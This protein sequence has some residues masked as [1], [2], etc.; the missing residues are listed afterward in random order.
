MAVNGAELL[1]YACLIFEE[2]Q[3]DKALE[4]FVLAYMNGF[5]QQLVLDTIYDCYMEGNMEE[6]RNAFQSCSQKTGITFEKC[7]LD[8]I[9]YRE[10]EYFIFDREEGVFRGTFSLKELEG[11]VSDSNFQDAEFSAGAWE[12]DWDWRQFQSDL[13][14]AKNRK[15]Y[16]IC[17][18]LER[19][20]SFCKVPE[21]AKYMK[22]VTIFPSRID[23]QDYFHKNI[24]IYLPRILSGDMDSARALAD[25][26]EEEHRYRLTTKG[27]N[28]ANVLLT[29]GIPTHNRG[30]LLLKRLENLCK[31]PYD[32]EVEIVISK[33]GSGQYEKE[34]NIVKDMS[35]ARIYYKDWDQELKAVENWHHVVEMAHGK[36]VLFVSDED[37]ICLDA[38]EHYLSCL[39]SYPSVS[40]V[41]AK[42]N[43][44]YSS[45][46]A[47]YAPQGIKAFR[48]S[49][50]VQ[51][52]LSGL[53]VRREDFLKENFNQLY[54]EFNTN[55]FLR[56]YPHE[57][58][59]AVLSQRGDYMSD[60]MTLIWEGES[61]N[62]LGINLNKEELVLPE[63]ATYEARLNQF[64]GMIDFL[65]WLMGD[66]SL[67]IAIGLYEAID[68]TTYLFMMARE[69]G[70]A[71]EHLK[72]WLARFYKAGI[73]AINEFS[74]KQEYA[75]QLLGTLKESCE[76]ILEQHNAMNKK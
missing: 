20:V 56:Y 14:E 52:Y 23:F 12:M 25:M 26:I 3:Y 30:K 75:T 16:V 27:R 58:W 44:T 35:D 63:Y 29:I 70:H 41:R 39:K 59:C 10:R 36:Y 33:N 18:D 51:N 72:E 74:L 1:D 22:H 7:T 48:A 65:H 38:L 54:R 69:Y 47:H 40:V 49:F 11:T 55:E 28:I 45:L 43:M 60:E 4:A 53:I 9:P 32:A 34:Y 64:Y 50:A 46:R 19:A 73:E 71:P 5:E 68:T 61:A 37:D 2:G 21:L 67:G 8:F 31:M 62:E 42:T 17:H 66:N 24:G 13:T 76:K 15:M 6:F 57:L